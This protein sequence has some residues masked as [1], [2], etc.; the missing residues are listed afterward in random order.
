MANYIIKLYVVEKQHN[1]LFDFQ[2]M[3]AYLTSSVGR[4]C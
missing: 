3:L 1:K 2:L 4:Y